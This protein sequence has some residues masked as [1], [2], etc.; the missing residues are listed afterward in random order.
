MVYWGKIFWKFYFI[1]FFGNMIDKFIDLVR[2]IVELILSVL[3]ILNVG[4]CVDLKVLLIL[5]IC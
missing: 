4:S 3:I 5:F 2:L 1:L